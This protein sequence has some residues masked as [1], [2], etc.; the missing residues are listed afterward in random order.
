[1]HSLNALLSC[2][3]KTLRT[4]DQKSP[5]RS[6]Q[7]AYHLLLSARLVWWDW[8]LWW[9]QSSLSAQCSSTRS[10][11]F[12][13]WSLAPWSRGW[14]QN[15]NIG[16][17]NVTLTLSLSWPF[18]ISEWAP[19]GPSLGQ[20][21]RYDW[22]PIWRTP[23]FSVCWRA[24]T[25]SSFVAPLLLFD[26]RLRISRKLSSSKLKHEKAKSETQRSDWSNWLVKTWPTCGYLQGERAE[27]SLGRV[28]VHTDLVLFQLLAEFKESFEEK[29]K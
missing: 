5:R 26:R 11:A 23:Y 14:K 17:S 13:C 12:A 3:F 15:G 6:L 7:T 4:R 29:L 16:Q 22:T 27:E 20:G 21:W 19:L 25:C 10:R 1:M 2:S 9:F 18:T 24:G 28:H 8:E